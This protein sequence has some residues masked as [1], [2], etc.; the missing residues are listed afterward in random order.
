[1]KQGF[2]YKATHNTRL[3]YIAAL[4]AASILLF[5][6][7]SETTEPTINTASD[8][9]AIAVKI[10]QLQLQSWQG[11]IKTFGV[12]EAAEEINISLDFSGIIQKVLVNEGERVSKGQLL[13]EL[14]QEKLQL[15]F[16]QASEYAIQTKAALDEAFLKLKRRKALAEQKT[17][18]REVLDNSE[19]ALNKAQAQYREA[20]A[21]QL[22][23]QR[24]LNDSKIYSPVNGVIDIKAV[25]P[26]ENI[27]AGNTLLTL[28]AVDTLRIKTWVSEKDINLIRNGASADVFLSSLPGT[29]FNSTVES[30]GV[31]AD[32]NT[33]N[34]PV[35]LII[36]KS[37]DLIRPGM[38]ASITINGLELKNRLLLPEQ[39]LVDRNR[40]KVVFVVNTNNDVLT[41]EKKQPLL[42]PA[43][44]D[45][46]FILSGLN[47]GE[48]LI[49]SSLDNIIDG[50]VIT[51]LE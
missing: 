50:S 5:T 8:N 30:V 14:D 12:V 9:R 37:S 38:T 35:K 6:A 18:S 11:K 31:N 41:A 32:P 40:K 46:L 16:Q 15:K 25:E 2:K 42:T 21:A 7:C 47:A 28:Q 51:L 3:P 36:E 17:V 26:G 20:I 44:Q 48:K 22:L 10:L 27:P 43:Q 13:I 1:M 19:L 29:T 39:A 24:E 49:I 33:G 45:Q 34:F 4:L 23:S